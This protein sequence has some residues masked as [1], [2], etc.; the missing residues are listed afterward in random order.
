[1]NPTPNPTLN[2]NQNI[3]RNNDN[4][5]RHHDKYP[6]HNDDHKTN[7]SNFPLGSIVLDSQSNLCAEKQYDF[8][9]GQK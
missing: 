1:M 6:R 7:N 4:Y 9:G 2:P 5:P 8:A 3:P